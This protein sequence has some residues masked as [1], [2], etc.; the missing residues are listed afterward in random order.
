MKLLSILLAALP[1]IIPFA[2]AIRMFES[3]SLNPCMANSSFSA[4]YFNV[5]FTPDNQTLS[6]SMNGVS[7]ISGNVYLDIKAL[8]YGYTFYHS[9]IDPC[10]DATLKGLC[11]MNQGDI[12]FPT[13]A[14]LPK[15]TIN[16]IPS[17]SSTRSP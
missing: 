5:L 13:N 2:S 17:K 3:D 9:K 6:I 15:S 4:T 11:P 16:Q 8:G 10:A 7:E 1:A 14:Q 12:N